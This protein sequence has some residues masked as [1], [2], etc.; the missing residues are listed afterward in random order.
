M[1]GSNSWTGAKEKKYEQICESLVHTTDQLESFW[2]M[3]RDARHRKPILHFVATILALFTV[4]WVGNRVNNFFLA[5]L[6]TTGAL[7]LPGLQKKGYLKQ[8]AAQ[9]TLKLGEVMKGKD[10]LKKAQ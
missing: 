4:A 5:Y 9:A 2:G 7:M 10:Y 6:L 8:F 3:C 1:F